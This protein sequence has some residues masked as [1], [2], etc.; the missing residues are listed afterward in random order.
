VAGESVGAGNVTAGG[1][2]PEVASTAREREALAWLYRFS[3]WE[4]GVGWSRDSAPEEVWKLGRTRALLDLAG[5][6]DHRLRIVHVAGTK[7]KGSTVTYLDSI[8][9]A[10]GWRT[11]AYTQPHLHTFRERIRLDGR[12]VDPERF[13]AGVDRLRG[14]VEQLRARHPDAG[15]PTTFELATVLAL[16]LFEEAGVDLAIVEVGLGGRLDATNALDTDLALIARI[17][18]DHRQILGRT[19]AEIAAEK[20]AIARPGRVALSSVQRPAAREVIDRYC[21]SVGARLRV[22]RPLRLRRGGGGGHEVAGRLATGERFAGKLGLAAQLEGVWGHQRQNAALAVAAAEELATEG[23]A[24]TGA[25]VEMGL[26]D[27]WLPARLELARVRPRILIDAAHNV[28]SARALA[29]ELK[30]WRNRPLWLVL[31][32]LRDKDASAIL[33]VLL[34]LAAGVV[35]VTPTSPRALPADVL[36]SSCRAISAVEIERASSVAAAIEMA[37]ERAGRDG[38]VAVAGSF[39]T[40]SEARDALGLRGVLTAEERRAWLDAGGLARVP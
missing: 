23:L 28:D 9:R 20:V 31:G 24:L 18:L 5:A 13:A 6:P 19:L 10:A 26:R 29:E 7:G 40:A 32:I 30:R 17:G 33:R 22:V 8:V 4:R 21:E 1:P 15:A 35:V 36:A 3:D 2:L 39:A 34:P 14:L 37:R 12:P 38:G 16:L 11:G 27:A 25:A